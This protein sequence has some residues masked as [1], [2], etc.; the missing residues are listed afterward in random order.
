[1]TSFAVGLFGG[2]AVVG[3]IFL[4]EWAW[5]RWADEKTCWPL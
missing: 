5:R 1:M 2:M 3:S 4:I